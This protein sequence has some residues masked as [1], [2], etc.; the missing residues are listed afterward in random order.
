MFTEINKSGGSFQLLLLSYIYFLLFPECGAFCFSPDIISD[1]PL[2]ITDIRL[3]NGMNGRVEMFVDGIWGTICSHT[4]G[5][6]EA[7]VVCRM[8]GLK[9][10]LIYGI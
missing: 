7:Q 8:L 2:N 5:A 6:K 3:V 10:V 1:F 9:Y 4:F